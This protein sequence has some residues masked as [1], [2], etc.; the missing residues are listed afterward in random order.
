M[1]CTSWHTTRSKP[2]YGVLRIAILQFLFGTLHVIL[3]SARRNPGKKEKGSRQALDTL[4]PII[5]A[6][7]SKRP[8]T[9]RI[10]NGGVHVDHIWIVC[11]CNYANNLGQILRISEAVSLYTLV[12]DTSTAALRNEAFSEEKF[13]SDLHE[14]A[15]RAK[16]EF[17]A[18]TH[19]L[20]SPG[21]TCDRLHC[22][23]PFSKVPPSLSACA[24]CQAICYCSRECQKEHWLHHKIV[25]KKPMSVMRD[26]AAVRAERA[27]MVD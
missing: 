14:L 24:G 22:P 11:T 18:T 21:P 6:P 3:S 4:D 23:I 2:G 9:A 12:K 5:H 13:W 19:S 10:A 15:M 7:D 26:E 8:P 25:C 20:S 27:A 17:S 16:V 1:I